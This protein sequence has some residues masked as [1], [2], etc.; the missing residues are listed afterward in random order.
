MKSV[1]QAIDIYSAVWPL[2]FM[3]R[4]FG[5]S[6]YS[7]KPNS[8]SAKHETLITCLCRMWSILCIDFLAALGYIF[9]TGSI[10]ANVT[11]RERITYILFNTSQF[12]CPI[13][14][15]LLSLT[16]NRGKVPEI[17][18]KFSEIDQLFSFKMYRVQIYKNTRLFLTVQFLTM[19]LIFIIMKKI[20]F[21]L[22]IR[23]FSVTVTFRLFP[24][25]IPMFLNC[26]TILHF[27]NIVLLLRN[28][29]K[30][31]NSELES[32]AFTTCNVT[33]LQYEL[34]DTNTELY[35]CNGAVSYRTERQLHVIKMLASS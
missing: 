23:H 30:Y 33:N 18:R 10:F 1:F 35:K 22:N 21:Y 4:I 28:K 8:Q 34:R 32:S 7:L 9:V 14:T 5:L 3:S 29:Y 20:L 15:L 31:L 16:P 19:I 12:S 6:P 13:I 26:T 27:V 2:H 17:L 11:L 24:Y 25:E